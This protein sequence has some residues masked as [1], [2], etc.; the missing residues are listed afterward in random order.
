MGGLGRGGRGG[1]NELLYAMG[2][3]AGGGGRLPLGCTSVRVGGWDVPSLA[4]FLQDVLFDG[5]LRD[6]AVR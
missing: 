5:A 4:G 1:L 3:W 2:G 6:K